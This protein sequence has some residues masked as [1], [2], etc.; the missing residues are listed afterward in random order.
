MAGLSAFELRHRGHMRGNLDGELLAGLGS[1]TD[2]AGGLGGGADGGHLADGA[3]GLDQGREVVRTHV[4]QRPGA[5][6]E[7]EGRVRVPGFRTRGLERSHAG[8]WRADVT[9]FNDAARGLQAGTQER[10]RCGSEADSRCICGLEEAQTG[11]T[12]QRERL[13][14]PYVLARVDGSGGY[15]DVRRRN[16]QVH[17]DFDVG[18]VQ[19]QLRRAKL[20]DPVFLG[21]GLGCLFEQVGDHQDFDVREGGEVIQ[22][23]LADVARA[24]DG[25]A[26]GALAG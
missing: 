23:L 20:G 25:D 26:Y 16:G 9:A 6:L 3:E 11:F 19:C 22:V 18:M 17:N 14:S 24:D 5:V 1:G 12:V 7:Q 4:E 15:L 13:L 21:A 10:V 8:Q 2:D